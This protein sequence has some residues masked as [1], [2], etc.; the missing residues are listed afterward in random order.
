VQAENQAQ[1][2]TAWVQYNVDKLKAELPDFTY[3]KSLELAG[4][5]KK[6]YGI[7]DATLQGV[8]D[9]RFFKLALDAVALR[10]S[11]EKGAP[12]PKEAKAAPKLVRSA[13]KPPVKGQG[14]RK[15]E[16]ERILKKTGKIADREAIFGDFV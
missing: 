1:K 11:K 15:A 9:Y 16:A 14:K 10:A 7:D 2:H 12:K 5:L 13:A 4:A 8:V 6:H 3:E